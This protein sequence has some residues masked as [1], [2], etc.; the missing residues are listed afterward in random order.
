MQ[1]AETPLEMAYRLDMCEPPGGMP[2]VAA[3]GERERP[4]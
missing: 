4:Q 3:I 2:S 1:H